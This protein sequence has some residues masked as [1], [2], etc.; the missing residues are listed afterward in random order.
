[1]TI[2][3][4]IYVYKCIYTYIYIY[5]YFL[6]AELTG[7]TKA[8]RVQCACPECGQQFASFHA[9]RVHIGKSHPQRSV[10]LSHCDYAHVAKRKNEHMQH[11]EAGRPQCR[12]CFKKFS[13]WPAFMAHF[14]QQA[15]PVLHTT[16]I[17][18]TEAGEQSSARLLLGRSC[19]GA[20][21]SLF[22]LCK[23]HCQFFN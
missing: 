6:Q 5:I 13:G 4:Y 18:V 14:N 10:A 1:M 15:C 8:V 7:V 3:I 2:Y 23:D 17:A 16:G 21:K 9:M 12:H 19:R 11:T 20:P 22:S